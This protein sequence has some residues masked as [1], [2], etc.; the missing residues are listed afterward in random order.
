MT[1][2][3]LELSKV[4]RYKCTTVGS[5]QLHCSILVLFAQSIDTRGTHIAHFHLHLSPYLVR[6][7]SLK[8]F[9]MGV[10]EIS[11]SYLK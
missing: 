8:K 7:F 4:I 9:T 1:L 11:S 3:D 5:C 2:N 6:D 10:V